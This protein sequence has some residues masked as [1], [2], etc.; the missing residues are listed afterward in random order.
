MKIYLDTKNLASLAKG[1]DGSVESTHARA[2]Q[3]WGERKQEK[4]ERN[5]KKNGNRTIIMDES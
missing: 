2:E 1:S 4:K 5:T 3:I